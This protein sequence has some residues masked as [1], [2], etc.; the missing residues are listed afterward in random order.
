[1]NVENKGRWTVLGIDPGLGVTGW[2][3]VG[4]A[5]NRIRHLANGQIRTD[6][7]LALPDRLVE[8][9]E[10]LVEVIKEHQPDAC[11]IEEVFV[12]ENPQST[13]KLV[14]ARGVLLLAAARAGMAIGEY[15]PR[16]VKKAVTGTG[17][18]GKEQ[19]RGMVSTLLPGVSVAGNDAA[20][21]LA[22]SMTHAHHLSTAKAMQART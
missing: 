8:L 4:L 1:M 12:N 11:G 15:A 19:V 2:G 7:T 17:T 9:H 3:I 21:A 6:K 16:V 22:V 20:D 10:A 5:G 18:A 13:I 14:Q